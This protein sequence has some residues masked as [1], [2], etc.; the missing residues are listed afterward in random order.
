MLQLK[1]D[2]WCSKRAEA[3]EEEKEAAEMEE[4]LSK[5][6]VWAKVGTQKWRDEEE[7]EEEELESEIE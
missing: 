2:Q 6:K 3:E 4:E 1:P 5:R 7:A